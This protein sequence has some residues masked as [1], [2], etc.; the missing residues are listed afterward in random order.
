AMRYEM[1]HRTPGED[2]RRQLFKYQTEL[3]EYLS[4]EWAKRLRQYHQDILLN[5]P[6]NDARNAG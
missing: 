5:H 4:P 1:N 2:F 3:M 6:F